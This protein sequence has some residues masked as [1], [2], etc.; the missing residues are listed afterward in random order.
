MATWVARGE[1]VYRRRAV[2]SGD[3]RDHANFERLQQLSTGVRY[4]FVHDVAVVNQ[5]ATTGALL[6]RALRGPGRMQQ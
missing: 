6:R 3:L 1:H 2:P 4:V 5:E